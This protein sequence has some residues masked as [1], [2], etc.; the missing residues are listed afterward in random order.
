[1]KN[2]IVL[3]FI[4]F[5]SFSGFDVCSDNSWATTM[6][7]LDT[8]SGDEEKVCKKRVDNRNYFPNFKLCKV[9]NGSFSNELITQQILELLFIEMS[10]VDSLLDNLIGYEVEQLLYAKNRALIHSTAMT[11]S[12]FNSVVDTATYNANNA[13]N[14][15][16]KKDVFLTQMRDILGYYYSLFFDM[17]NR[18]VS[19]DPVELRA[20]HVSLLM[21]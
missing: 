10:V 4:F 16:P 18:N 15:S 1:M 21:P 3:L 2:A 8:M 9:E 5:L 12:L 17:Q 7:I 6:Q 14:K 19:F 20:Q 11:I 13:F